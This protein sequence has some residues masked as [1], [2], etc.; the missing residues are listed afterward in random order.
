MRLSSSPRVTQ[1]IN[2]EMELRHLARV[3]TPDHVGQCWLLALLWYLLIKENV[4]ILS[5]IEYREHALWS[6]PYRPLLTS[7]K[8]S[9]MMPS[10]KFQF[11]TAMFTALN[12][13]D[14]CLN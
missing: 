7:L 1:L 8:V 10:E 4:L 12:A 5:V 6:L 3:W 2:P 14:I 13:K 11:S 9:R